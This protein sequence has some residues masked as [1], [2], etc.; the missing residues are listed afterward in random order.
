M[1]QAIRINGIWCMPTNVYVYMGK[2]VK[3][4]EK[5]NNV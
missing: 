5:K 2:H 3:H 4:R 1:Y